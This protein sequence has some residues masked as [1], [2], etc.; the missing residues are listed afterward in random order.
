MADDSTTFPILNESE[1]HVLRQ[2]GS[3][4]TFSNGDALWN[5]GDTEFCFFVVL[6]GGVIIRDTYRETTQVAYHGPGNFTGD[7]DILNGRPAPV[8]GYADGTTIVL[9]ISAARLREIVRLEQDLGGKILAAFIRRRELLLS[10]IDHGH[11]LIGSQYDPET[12]ALRTFLA[13]NRVVH[14][15]KKPEDP[16]TAD[17]LNAFDLTVADTPIV[18]LGNERLLHPTIDDLASRL[19]IRRITNNTQYDLV[20]VGAGPAGLAAAVYGASEG[21]KTLVVDKSGPGGQA[22]WSSRIENYM[23]FPEGLTGS[24]LAARGVVQAQKFGADLSVPADVVDI[25]CNGQEKKVHLRSGETVDAR[26]ILVAT[27]ANYQKLNV[28]G[29]QKLERSG[30][31][32]AA[33]SI[34]TAFCSDIEIVVVGAGNSAGQAAVFLSQ[35]SKQVTLIVRG[36]RLNKSMSDY[37]SYRVEQIP[38]IKIH[39]DTEVAE[40]IGDDKVTG[41]RLT[42]K[43]NDTVAC[44]G[45]FVFIGAHPN[46]EFIR[47]NVAVDNNGFILTGEATADSWKAERS[48]YYLETSCP[49]VFAAG[50]CRAGSVK[51]VASSVGEGSMAVTFIHNFLSL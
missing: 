25:V 34:E 6:S 45:F 14:Q 46:T 24:D 12:Q 35:T 36:D 15:W 20:I 39:L 18:L 31:Y 51:R 22:S 19:G 8:G 49:G 50:D 27:G 38:N 48:P 7:V 42:G 30:I 5:A 21:L 4:S 1:I 37:L 17:I 23:G 2:Y 29:Y 13:R 40:V 33:T 10:T 9:Q 16:A 43:I 11:I 41:V 32:Y 3:E 47:N 44:D 28:P 26:S